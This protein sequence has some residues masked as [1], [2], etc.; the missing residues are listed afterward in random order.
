MLSEHW[1]RQILIS[2]TF[3][4]WVLA[5]KFGDPAYSAKASDNGI[6]EV[7]TEGQKEVDNVVE[8]TNVSSN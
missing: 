4:K 7:V 5:T 1:R 6:W 2:T 3:D 8:V